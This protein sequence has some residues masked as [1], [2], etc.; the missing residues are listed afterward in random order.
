MPPDANSIGLRI[1][2]QNVTGA[3]ASP[4][5][6]LLDEPTLISD[7]IANA[8]TAGRPGLEQRIL[9]ALNHQSLQGAMLTA[10]AASLAAAGR[11]DM[12]Q[13]VP[14]SVHF[15][16]RLPGNSIDCLLTPVGLPGVAQNLRV[17]FDAEI[18]F[19]LAAEVVEIRSAS[20]S[21]SNVS[22]SGVFSSLYGF[23]SGLVQALIDG[24]VTYLVNLINGGL[25]N[26]PAIQ[27]YRKT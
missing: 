8:W 7:Q 10:T 14:G 9:D 26:R 5:T 6:A 2:F 4:P 12:A 11:L 24:Q 22:I 15:R 18:S 1:L 17:T 27:D 19:S 23:F 25:S 13:G 16:F 3:I 21:I 20:A